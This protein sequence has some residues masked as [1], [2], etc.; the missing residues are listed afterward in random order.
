VKRYEVGALALSSYGLEPPEVSLW[1]DGE[2]FL[3]GALSP[4]NYRRYV[5]VG[6]V[7]HLIDKTDLSIFDR[8]WIALVDLQLLPK[9]S[10]LESLSIPAL[11]ELVNYEGRWQLRGREVD[12][13][14]DALVTLVEQWSHAQAFKVSPYKKVDDAETVTVKL[15]GEVMSVV[16]QLAEEGDEWL[17]GRSD[18]GIQ[19]HLTA[20]QAQRLLSFTVDD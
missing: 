3:F 20:E 13:S 17:L 18:L 2:A 10:K 1:V 11:G 4:V 12:V 16:F 6:G 14:A 7:L 8:G 15:V 19:Y 9:G 5:W